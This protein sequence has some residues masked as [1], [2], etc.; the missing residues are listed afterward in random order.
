[1]YPTIHSYKSDTLT[2]QGFGPLA[3]CTFCE[4]TEELNGGYT[5]ELHYPIKGENYE[6]I[7]PGNIIMV[8]PSHNHKRQ[9][10]RI[11]QVKRSFANSIVVYANHISYDLGGYVVRRPRS[12]NSL[13]ETIYNMNDMNWGNFYPIYNKFT[14]RTD[15]SSNKPF[16]MPGIQTM[17]SWMGGQEGSIIDTYGGEWDYDMFTIVLWKRRGKDT[18]IRISYGNNLAEYEKQRD[19]TLYSHVCAY[20]TN[21]ETTVYTDLIPTG[22]DYFFRVAYID[23]SEKFEETPTVE[24]LTEIARDR[25]PEYAIEFQSVNVTPVQIGTVLGL[26]DSVYICYES[27]FEMRVVKTV[28]DALSGTYKSLTLGRRKESISET[29]KSLVNGR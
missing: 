23:L 4:V 9:P 3:D 13:A 26:G 29:I 14:F 7:V 6:H 2:T 27:V 24:Q 8:K 18:G 22:V 19:N 25:A 28:W 15:I 10:F 17:R 12:Y 16:H 11:S 21:D 5:M 1:M 20:W